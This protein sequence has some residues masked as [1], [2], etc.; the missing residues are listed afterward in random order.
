MDEREKAIKEEEKKIRMLRRLV[1]LTMA[2]LMQSSLSP[3]E[4]LNLVEGTKRAAL[5]LF[6]D[7]EFVYDLVYTPRFRRIIAER[8]GIA[9]T[10]HSRN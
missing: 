1:D 5:T 3:E 4:A 10:E 8:F 2:I 6:P 7:K 9:G